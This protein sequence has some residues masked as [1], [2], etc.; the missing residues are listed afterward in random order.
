MGS[1]AKLESIELIAPGP[2]RSSASSPVASCYLLLPDGTRFYE[3][4]KEVGSIA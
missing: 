3:R 4:L 2:N 1:F